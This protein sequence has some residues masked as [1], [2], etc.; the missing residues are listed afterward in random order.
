[1]P[2]WVPPVTEQQ[3]VEVSP[4]QPAQYGWQIVEVVAGH[5][6]NVWVPPVTQQ[7]W[8]Q[9]SPAVPAQYGWQTVEVTAGHWSNVWVPPVTQQQWVQISPAVPAQGEWRDVVVGTSSTPPATEWRWVETS[10]AVPAQAARWDWQTIEISPGRHEYAWMPP[11][12]QTRRVQTSPGSPAVFTS[13]EIIVS[14]GR[15]ESTWIPPETRV[16][17]VQISPAIPPIYETREIIVSPG[18]W[19]SVWIPAVTRTERVL[20]HPFIPAEW[21]DVVV[22]D[23]PT[24]RWV[25]T[26]PAIPARYEQ[27]TVV[28]TPA[29]TVPAVT[30]Q[31]WVQTAAAVPAR[32]AQGHWTTVVTRREELVPYQLSFRPED[33]ICLRPRTIFVHVRGYSIPVLVSLPSIPLYTGRWPFV[34]TVWVTIPAATEQRWVQTAAAV[35]A[36]AAQGYWTTVVITPARTIPA[37]TR[38]ETVQVSPFRPAEGHWVTVP[39][40]YRVVGR[41]LIRPEQAAV[42]EE[43]TVIVSPGRMETVWVPPVTRTET[44]VISPG[45]PAEYR[46]TETVVTPGRWENTWIP[47][48]TRTETVEISPAVPPTYET[49]EE[50]IPGRFERVWIPAVTETR[51][52]EVAP[53]VAGQPAQG[54][55][56]PV[57]SRRTSRWVETSPAMPATGE[58]REIV[59]SPARTL[60]A[61]TTT[62]TIWSPSGHW[63]SLRGTIMVERDRELVFTERWRAANRQYDMGIT[64][65]YSLNRK[66]VRVQAVHVLNRY[67]NMGQLHVRPAMQSSIP[68]RT[69]M[70]FIYRHPGQ[71]TSTLFIRLH[72]AGG[73]TFQVEMQIPVNGITVTQRTG[74]GSE[75]FNRAVARVGTINIP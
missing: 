33:F 49:V 24:Q 37:V 43:R 20:V 5:W 16:E 31:Q 17:R 75:A 44:V 26:A 61:V 21:R 68:G 15:W 54:H 55:W 6:S 45:A 46:V 12:T 10:P 1:M 60:P 2:Y 29:T 36:R 50:T 71:V 73:E 56:E 30:K 13:R 53:A 35:P 57:I 52:V 67:Q 34:I 18:R 14:P 39:G 22:F 66:V 72:F 25:Q 40:G 8:V 70:G 27:R 41:I 28:I 4:A 32:E 69:V 38:T 3:W 11:R 58:Y 48:V 63:E 59:V 9:I 62:E 7:Q 74:L 47:P 64:L 42:Y 23:P 65:T 51:L 19:E